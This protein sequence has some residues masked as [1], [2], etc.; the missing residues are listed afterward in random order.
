[1]QR[2]GDYANTLYYIDMI[3]HIRGT[4]ADITQSNIVI[5]VGGVGYLVHTQNPD[6]FTID[7]KILLHTH[8]AVQ[9][10]SQDLYGF[11]TRDE[12]E[13]FTLLLS[14]PKIGPKSA[15]QIMQKAD[16]ELLK[17]SVLSNDAAHLSKISGIGKKTAEKIVLG[18]KD[19]F[20]HFT[21]S[22]T[23]DGVDTPLHS[24]TVDAIDALISLGYP[25]ADART[26][27]QNLPATI[28]NA[29]DAIKAALKEL[30]KQ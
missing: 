26:T 15:M 12:L 23:T 27:I 28:T 10:R 29:N 21:G 5:D 24:Y 14:L 9:E 18:L 7:S 25:Q 3:R 6:Q 11:C 4:I 13:L 1:M 22:C 8:M 16:I 30:G 2:L 19:S 20:E 17:V